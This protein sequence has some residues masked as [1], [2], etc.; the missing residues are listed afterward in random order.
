MED[1]W[2]SHWDTIFS[3]YCAKSLQGNGSYYILNIDEYETLVELES[4]FENIN[5]LTNLDFS[6]L[7]TKLQPE[8]STT[9][10]ITSRYAGAGE[11]WGAGGLQPFPIIC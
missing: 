1:E 8:K 10:Y 11:F 9:W 2:P 3:S 4:Q 6:T 5:E 7:R